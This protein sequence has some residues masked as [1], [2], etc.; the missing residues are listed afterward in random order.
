MQE[1][2]GQDETTTPVTEEEIEE[3]EDH[4]KKL[5]YEQL[6]LCYSTDNQRKLM[7]RKPLNDIIDV[8]KGD[9]SHIRGTVDKPLCT[10]STK[11]ILQCF[12]LVIIIP[13]EIPTC[14]GK[15]SH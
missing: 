12:P 8:V 2:I 9:I 11:K 6:Q 1:V 13:S 4:H 10:I 15:V 14:G 5:F 7:G 3:E